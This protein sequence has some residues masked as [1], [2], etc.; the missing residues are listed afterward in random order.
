[1]EDELSWAEEYLCFQLMCRNK[2][3][4]H[5]DYDGCTKPY[6]CYKSDVEGQLS[7]GTTPVEA[8]KMALDRLAFSACED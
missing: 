4:L 1:V 7:R 8:I 6:V 3:R 2:I 5:Y